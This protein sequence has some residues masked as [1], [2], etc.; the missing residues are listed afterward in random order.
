MTKRGAVWGKGPRLGQ[1]VAF[2]RARKKR[3]GGQLAL[4][5]ESG[6]G[7]Q[8]GARP[9]GYGAGAERGKG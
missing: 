9:L 3:R 8:A 6:Q 1:L 4:S 2:G 5:L 7:L